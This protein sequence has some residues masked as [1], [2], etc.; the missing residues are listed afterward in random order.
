[1]VDVRLDHGLWV[2]SGHLERERRVREA[3]K[4]EIKQIESHDTS[5][6][7]TLRMVPRPALRAYTE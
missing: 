2:T 7:A 3:N 4:N 5:N 1:M 6:E